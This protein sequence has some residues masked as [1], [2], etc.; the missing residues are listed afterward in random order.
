M[1]LYHS[2][3]RF[4]VVLPFCY[5]FSEAK[6]SDLDTLTGLHQDIASCQVSVHHSMILQVGHT[7]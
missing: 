7:L 2:S 4:V 5:E 6:V 1:I 3:C